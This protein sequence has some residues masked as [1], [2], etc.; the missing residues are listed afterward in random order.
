MR[1]LAI[2]LLAAAVLLPSLFMLGVDRPMMT[3]MHETQ[4]ASGDCVD[5]CLQAS[6]GMLAAPLF[7]PSLAAFGLILIALGV[8]DADHAFRRS[9]LTYRFLDDFQKILKKRVVAATVLRN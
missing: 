2:I 7:A 8:A 3:A 1:H 4:G 9:G 5:H 6:K